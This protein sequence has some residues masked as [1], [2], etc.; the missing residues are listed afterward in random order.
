[1]SKFNITSSGWTFEN[2]ALGIKIERKKTFSNQ[3]EAIVDIGMFRKSIKLAGVG[4]PTV[5]KNIKES[6]AV[7]IPGKKRKKKK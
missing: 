5:E 7:K 6:P 3:S 4:T 1:M 2:E